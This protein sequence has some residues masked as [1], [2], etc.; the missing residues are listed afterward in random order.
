MS[1]TW[2]FRDPST[3]ETVYW[4]A[5][6]ASMVVVQAASAARR[7]HLLAGHEREL[8]LIKSAALIVWSIDEIVRGTTPFRRVLGAATLGWQIRGLLRRA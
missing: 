7:L 8:E 3:G 4:Q 2:W 6:N 5:P 1:L